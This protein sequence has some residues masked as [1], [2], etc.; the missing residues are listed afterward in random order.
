VAVVVT[1]DPTFRP[2][3]YG[4]SD[5]RELGAQVGFSFTPKH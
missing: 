4:I 2:S 3:D 1:A 5:S